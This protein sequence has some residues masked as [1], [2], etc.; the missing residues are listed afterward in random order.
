MAKDSLQQ[1]FQIILLPLRGHSLKFL[2]AGAE[3][4]GRTDMEH[5]LSIPDAHKDLAGC[6]VVRLDYYRN[7]LSVACYSFIHICTRREALFDLQ[8]P[9]PAH[10]PPMKRANLAWAPKIVLK[11]SSASE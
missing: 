9:W 10:I 11:S 3:L 2:R 6:D 1:G 5:Q 8:H 7:A 4:A